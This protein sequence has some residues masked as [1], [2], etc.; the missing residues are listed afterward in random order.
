MKQRLSFVLGFLVVLI[1]FA[2]LTRIW[3]I[4]EQSLWFDEAWSAYAA[5]QPS[6]VD[7]A[8]AD[9]TNPPLYYALLNGYTSFAGDS[10]FSLRLFSLLAGI[11]VIPLVCQ[12]GLRLFNQRVALVSAVISAVMPLLWWASREARMYTLIAVFAL[13]CALSFHT[14]LNKP[15][16]TAWIALWAAELALLHTHNT[17]PIVVLWLNIGVVIA[18]ASRRSFRHPNWRIWLAGQVVVGLLWLPYFANR[19]LLLPE[20]NSALGQTVQFSGQFLFSLW[21][22]FWITPWERILFADENGLAI[23]ALLVLTVAFIPYRKSGVRWLLMHSLIWIGGIVV[24]LFVLGNELHG[25]YLVIAAPFVAILIGTAASSPRRVWLQAVCLILPIAFFTVNLVYNDAPEYRRDDARGMARYYAETLGED[26]SVLAWSY[27]DRYDLA[28]YWEREEVTAQRITLPEGADYADIA[29]LLPDSGDVALNIWY[30]QRADYRGMLDCLLSAGTVNVPDEFTTYGMTSRLYRQPE[31]SFP[32][33]ERFST[34]ILVNGTPAAQVI[35]AAVPPAQRPDQAV[36]LP[37]Q[38][39]LQS[40]IP[41]DLKAAVIVT[42]DLGDEIARADAPFAT[43][44][45]RTSSSADAGEMLTAYPLIRLPVGTPPGEYAVWLRVYDENDEP[46]G[47]PLTSLTSIIVGRDVLLGTWT[48]LPGADWSQV[49]RAIELPAQV[50]MPLNGLSLMAHNAGEQPQPLRNG[51]SLRFTLLW[52]GDSQ[53]PL[54]VLTLDDSDGAWQVDIPPTVTEHDALMRDWREVLIP[55]NASSGTAVL[56]LPDGTELARYTIQSVE[57]EYGLPSL[58]QMVQVIFSGVGEL[59][60]VNYPQLPLTL[61][62]SPRI[63]LIWR[64]GETP[65]PMSYTVFV[66]LLNPQG[67]VIAQSDSIPS[68]GER[69]MTGWRQDEIIRDIHNLTYNESAIAGPVS[70]IIGMYDPVTG[71]RVTLADSSDYVTV[72]NLEISADI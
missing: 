18:W 34:N 54:P 39:T 58:D 36:C 61:D 16:R 12:L 59:V 23:F 15:K 38:L 42:N 65:S 29:P 53:T 14:L 19:F 51:D 35:R 45:Q 68:Q 22:A 5:A 49:N 31:F 40:P 67:Q 33:L 21:Q 1:L 8:N 28:Y 7:A 55:A 13:I 43:A 44:N 11:L 72:N 2:F 9:S 17:G 27:A 25:R 46:S 57:A 60:G 10:E 71:L 6:F 20:A 70:L 62:E 64:G 26:D 50:Q 66:Q 63:E 3:A 37:I 32:D 52:H 30:T 41:S 56:R 47:Y 4:G 69:P 48:A 24:G